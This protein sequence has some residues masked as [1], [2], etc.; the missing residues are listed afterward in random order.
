[1]P[2]SARGRVFAGRYRTEFQIGEGATATVWGGVDTTLGRRVAVKV[3]RGCAAAD[4]DARARFKREAR[5]AASFSSP[6]IVSVYDWGEQDGCFYLVMEY[7][8]GTDLAALVARQGH[9]SPRRCAELGAQ[10][11]DAL[12]EIHAKGLVHRDVKPHNIVVGASGRAKLTDFGIARRLASPRTTAQTSVL[13][14]AAYA[15]PEQAAGRPVGP[16]SDIYSLGAVL[17]ECA[18]G[19]P[20]FEGSDA[21]EVALKHVNEQP[22]PL[23]QVS[24]AVD[25]DLNAVVMTCLEKDPSRR[26]G[27]ARGLRE[28]LRACAEGRPSGVSWTRAFPPAVGVISAAQAPLPAMLPP[29]EGVRMPQVPSAPR[30]K[31]APGRKASLRKAAVAAGAAALAVVCACATAW[32]LSALGGSQDAQGT[33]DG[34]QAAAG[35]AAEERPSAMVAVPDVRGMGAEQ[36][37]Q[38]LVRS[39]LVLGTCSEEPSADVPEGEVTRSTPTAG[40]EVMEG[41]RVSLYVSAGRARAE[42]PDIAAGEAERGARGKL[43]AAG[44]LP[45]HEPALDAYDELVEQGAFL[46]LDAN[47]SQRDLLTG[48]EVMY[49]LSLG[50]DPALSEVEVADYSWWMFP[51]ASSALA[52]SGLK[53]EKV[54][55]AS[56]DHQAEQVVGQDVAPGTKVQK[57]STVVL[58]VSD[59]SSYS[60]PQGGSSASGSQGGGYVVVPDFA[61]WDQQNAAAELAGAGLSIW[62]SSEYSQTVPAG[63]VIRTSPGAGQPAYS[64]VEVVVSA[65]APPAAQAP[66]EVPAEFWEEMG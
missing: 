2:E 18:C 37:E 31:D 10:V 58:Y 49:G 35:A 63:Y 16:A 12:C 27:D 1:M 3:L 64:S 23:A 41:G 26:F 11:A 60:P 62:V 47:A 29:Y 15:S 50:K 45:V 21:A 4:P 39:G 5:A 57:G 22:V 40:V 46:A 32:A 13:G 24:P 7:L 61:M 66:S 53:V 17:Y 34:P 42:L 38:L 36:A 20:P 55:Q 30:R 65:G 43:E 8:E 33:T 59:G 25:D 56:S 9:L 48:D 54:Y 28:A 19:R 51:D 6:H 14:T 44:L 52:L